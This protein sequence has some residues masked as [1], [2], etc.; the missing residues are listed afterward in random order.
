MKT[1]SSL[2]THFQKMQI[3]YKK[4]NQK[5]IYKIFNEYNQC[6]LVLLVLLDSFGF[7]SLIQ[8]CINVLCFS[9][10]VSRA[11]LSEASLR[12]SLRAAFL[13]LQSKRRCLSVILSHNALKS[14]M[15]FFSSS[16]TAFYSCCFCS[17]FLTSS[18]YFL[19]ASLHSFPLGSFN[20]SQSDSLV[21]DVQTPKRQ[22]LLLL[23]FE[24][25]ALD[26]LFLL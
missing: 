23:L 15:T 22:T 26:M 3:C 2:P 7:N 12:H 19:T 21:Q 11:S 6:L 24:A 25:L 18:W 8:T 17:Y 9:P 4:E 20:F 1:R 10:Q 14:P 16:L 13:L 5:K